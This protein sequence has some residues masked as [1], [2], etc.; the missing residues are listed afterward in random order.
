MERI[1]PIQ[2]TLLSLSA[3]EVNLKVSTRSS[4]TRARESPT[5]PEIHRDSIVSSGQNIIIKRRCL[6]QDKACV[7]VPPTIGPVTEPMLHIA[8]IIPN[9][10]P[11]ASKAPNR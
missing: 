6:T 11:L 9:H 3:S 2:S 7:N 1:D 4:G 10:W 5:N 8:L